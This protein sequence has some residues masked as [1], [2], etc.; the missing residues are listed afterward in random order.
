[1][2]DLLVVGEINVDLILQDETIAP[3]FGQEIVV[4]DALLT[5]GSSSV[6][7]ACGAARLG[8]DTAFFGLTGADEF[9]AF[10]R[11]EMAK[12]GVDVS[13]VVADPALRTGLTVSLSTAKDRAM[14][15]FMGSI[16]A[17]TADRVPDDLL[18]SARHLHC[19]SFFLQERLRPGL[20]DL[21]RR[22]RARGLTVSLDLGWDPEG[23]WGSELERVIDLVDV[24]VP[25]ETEALHL[26]GA[27]TVEEALERLAARVPTVAVKLGP[28]GAAA[29]SGA[30][31]ARAE[32]IPA[33]V[34]DTT[35]AGDSFNAGFIY[36]YLKGW[37]LERALRL[38]CACGSLSTEAAGGTT[39]Q[40]TLARAMEAAGL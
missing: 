1:M 32:A 11:R 40:P 9:G 13:R 2:H 25:N 26:T 27:D 14:I 22:A 36:G 39:A 34:V 33:T 23:R 19:G 12:L 10:M 7:M 28:Q 17:L 15:T 24:L 6:I 38:G 3:V 5:P 35:G 20:P 18:G 29:A 4:K 31:R 21:F 16:D 37:P 8:L 30:E